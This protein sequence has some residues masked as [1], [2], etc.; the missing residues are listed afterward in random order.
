MNQRASLYI[1]TLAK[2][3]SVTRA[4]DRLYITPS[5]LS[6]YIS[7][8]EREAG[9][10]L[11]SR[12]GKHFVLTY[13][14]ERYLDW[15]LRLDALS[16]QMENEMRDLSKQREGKIRLG[17]QSAISVFIV[18]QVV[19]KFTR[20]YP[21][22]C[23]SLTESTSLP[24]LE[25]VKSFQ[26]DAAIS[27]KPPNAE[28]FHQEPLLSMEQVLL[29]PK[30]HPLVK[31]AVQKPDRRYPWVDLDWCRGERFVV[32]HP[33]QSPRLQLEKLL[34]PIWE[35]IQIVMEVHSMRTMVS[36]V[37]SRIGII[38][39]GAGMDRLYCD[40]SDDL[41]R[42]SFGDKHTLQSYCLFYYKDIYQSKAMKDFLDIV[43][44]QF[45]LLEASE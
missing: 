37:K 39:T 34:A 13:A 19:P 31:R 26:L 44:T 45:R 11:F 3:G 30:E 43:R 4:A 35:D 7:A 25:Q 33:G 27:T 29:V 40:P 42:L 20:E 38:Q 5:A 9:T 6:K 12:I 18:E 41:V 21:D 17:V 24:I 10:P 23:V 22:I 15:C 2:Y 36:A 14:G 1:Q 32:M 28:P 8:L 16:A